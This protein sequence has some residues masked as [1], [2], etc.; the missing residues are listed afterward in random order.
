MEKILKDIL[1]EVNSEDKQVH[2]EL[3]TMVKNIHDKAMLLQ[4]RGDSSIDLIVL[5]NDRTTKMAHCG[6]VGNLDTII[7]SLVE[8][9]SRV[10][11]EKQDAIRMEMYTIFLNV[12]LNAA[13]YDIRKLIG[14]KEA[15][16]FILTSRGILPDTPN[17]EDE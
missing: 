8:M 3:A 1:R 10:Y 2:E 16:K 7:D 4:S 14:L 6:K 9:I 15:L 11:D 5:L 13:N 17:E 12:V